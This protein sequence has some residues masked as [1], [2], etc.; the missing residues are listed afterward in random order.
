MNRAA[1]A[2]LWGLVI[3]TGLCLAGAP[4]MP[5][6]IEFENSAEF[7]RLGKTVLEARLLDDMSDPAR[8]VFEGQGRLTALAKTGPRG[9]PALRVDVTMYHDSPAPTRNGL[10][11]VTLRRPF[12]GEDWTSY[13]RISF[14]IRPELSGFPVLPIVVVLRNEG[15]VK[16]PD[17]YR[18]EGV[19]YVT[20]LDRKWQ[21]V[22]WEIA[23][24]ARDKVV[25][26]EFGYWV[27][28]RL[29]AAGDAVAFEIARL[30][31]ERV[32]PDHYEGWQAAPGGIAFSH[33]GY[34]SEA[35]KTALA[36]D[37][38]AT[39]FELIRLDNNVQGEIVLSKP[40]EERR[41]RLGR[42]QVLDFSEVRAP[43]RY[44]IQA[45]PRRTRSFRIA[46]DVW[47]GT[48]WKAI[49]F[50]Y[51]ERC[52]YPVPGMHDV[53]H[54]DWQAALGDKRIVIN[55]GWHDAGDLSQGLVNTGEATYAM[56]ALAER[57]QRTGED[58]ELLVRLLEEALW[59]LDWVLQARFEGGYRIGFAGMNLWTNGILGDADDR[60]A[61]A[62]NN[63]TV[64][65]IA[66][67][68]EAVAAR[69]LSGRE[70]ELAARSLRTAEDDWR[71]AI[72]GEETP[73]TRST[74]AYAATPME[75]AA[76]GALAS[77]ELYQAT[78]KPLYAEKAF[79]LARVVLGSQQQT[80]LGSDF[81]LSGFFYTGPDK[82]AIFHQFHRANDQA[83]VTALVKL[84]EL[85][86]EHEEWIEWYA[87]AV[88]Y[89]EY[90]KRAALSTEPYAVLPAYV[91]KDTEYLEVPESGGPY[92]ATREDYRQQVL[93]GLPMGQGYYL[94]AFPV[95]FARRG[96]YGVLLSQTKALAAAARLRRDP[97]AADLAE[98]QLQWIVGR[99]P[100][101]QSTMY[102]EGYDWTQ[103][104]S[105]SSGDMV[106]A[107]PVGIQTRGNS[108]VPYWP[109]QNC[110][111][112]KEVWVHPAARW[113]WIMEELA[114]PGSIQAPERAERADTLPPG[115]RHPLVFKLAA[116][117]EETGLVT[118][119]L[120]ASGEGRHRFALRA[121]NLEP[122]RPARELALRPGA[123]GEL[124][125]RARLV[126]PDAPWVAVAF[127]DGNV[128]RRREL[129]GWDPR[130]DLRLGRNPGKDPDSGRTLPIR[131]EAH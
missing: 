71:W 88:L 55:G 112:Y 73:E 24:L 103:L 50:F 39:R 6:P 100:F 117:T 111:V 119:R 72:A 120:T 46:P 33:T 82:K 7:R 26:L 95:W 25:S 91:Y 110:Y 67:A 31:L 79:E 94:K 76:M 41:T 97:A 27:N 84:C 37:L 62:R 40:V 17:V 87:G 35:S 77:A 78:A 53:C 10:A 45:G 36:S 81:P 126:R 80:F 38:P 114:G 49:N 18:R 65:Y 108:D 85:F 52:G 34:S 5:M 128:A 64:N 66:A 69:V 22:L 83:P 13:N 12:S 61:Q 107:L 11:A 90:L 124:I 28:K 58:P 59:G 9:T 109:A 60:I 74:L 8:W 98:R 48:I 93:G 14:W 86:P 121:W 42:F 96:N 129:V 21:R 57:F 102:G 131:R 43:G 32:E 99:N 63:P 68:A 75:L 3:A 104:Y 92:Q 89:S 16:V 130:F 47:K 19:H 116:T 127:P 20:L 23:P 125:W 2:C 29:A 4:R 118:I 1:P 101:G 70:P 105:V 30:E 123:S 113:L 54:R 106:G 15:A 122:D 56:F 44:V 51:C 115:V